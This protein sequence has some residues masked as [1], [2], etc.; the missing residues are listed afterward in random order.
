[1]FLEIVLDPLPK[2]DIDIRVLFHFLL[3]LRPLEMLVDLHDILEV[4]ECKY[5]AR[6][7]NDEHR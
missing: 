1:M 4:V 2:E 5:P 7:V 3:P 6:L